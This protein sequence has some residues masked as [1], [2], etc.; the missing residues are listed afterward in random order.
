MATLSWEERIAQV[1]SKFIMDHPFFAV[2]ALHMDIREAEQ[3][4]GVSTMATDGKRLI[5]NP[6]FLNGLSEGE[7]V[8]VV[9]HE[10]LHAALEHPFRLNGRDP[11]L[12][13]V[14]M[15]FVIN[16]MLDEYGFKARPKGALV[17][18]AHRGKAW[19]DIYEELLR[20]AKQVA[21]LAAAAK[22]GAKPHEAC[23]EVR[24]YEGDGD[25]EGA[26]YGK[27]LDADAAREVAQAEM[28][29]IVQQ[30]AMAESAKGVGSLPGFVERILKAAKPVVDWRAVLRQFLS[31]TNTRVEDW[32]RPS[33]RNDALTQ[34][35]GVGLGRSIYMPG[36]RSEQAIGH[37]VFAVDTSGSISV[38]QLSSAMAEMQEA[39][40][41]CG[42]EKVTVIYCDA[43]VAATY[44]LDLLAG[45]ELNEE[46]AKPKGG[47]GTAF[48]PVF[49]WVRMH[50]EIPIG[51]VYVTDLQ[52]YDFGPEPPYPV[53]WLVNDASNG[54]EGWISKAVAH[55]GEAVRMPA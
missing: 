21:S 23:G 27:A 55:F 5:V 22:A 35:L 30:A 43:A 7:A 53:L 29:Q 25:G 26:V 8:Y 12:A 10:V 40:S 49:E 48:A 54:V 1:R 47:G 2:V 20:E 36:R 34:Q 9:A 38:P 39:C 42:I 6:T 24:P 45:D 4:D 11:T 41:T 37:M 19:E 16:L 15:D 14:A 3:S 51:L 46:T 52:C 44:E 32:S 17:D 31:A 13:N 28:R 18:P 33:K 50:V